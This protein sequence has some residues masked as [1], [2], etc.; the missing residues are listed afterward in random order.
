MINFIIQLAIN[1]KKLFR[2]KS[3]VFLANWF[4]VVIIFDTK[5]NYLFVSN[6]EICVQMLFCMI[7][8]FSVKSNQ[9]PV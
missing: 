9:F 8:A 1:V 2:I 6:Y 7:R 3:K 5:S 4:K